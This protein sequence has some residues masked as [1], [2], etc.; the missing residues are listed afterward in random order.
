VKNR[1]NITVSDHLLQQ[2]KNYAYRH[3]TSISQLVEDYFTRLT[4]PAKKKNILDVLRDLPKP[5]QRNT[6]DLKEKY[7]REQ[8]RK[9]GF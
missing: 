5:K 2:M 6:G 4:R 8:K 1:L 9:Y 3:N 7:F